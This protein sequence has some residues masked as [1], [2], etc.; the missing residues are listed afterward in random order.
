LPVLGELRSWVLAVLPLLI[1]IVKPSI[2]L[3]L[4]STIVPLPWSSMVVVGQFER[5]FMRVGRCHYGIC[6]KEVKIAGI[7]KLSEQGINYR[8]RAGNENIKISAFS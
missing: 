1:V 3:A 5:Q 2:F 4:F 6:Q 7:I 8:E